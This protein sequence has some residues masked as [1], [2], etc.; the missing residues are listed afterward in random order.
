MSLNK[1]PTLAS[2]SL[3]AAMQSACRKAP[4]PPA[5]TPKDLHFCDPNYNANL[6]RVTVQGQTVI[7]QPVADLNVY[8]HQ[9]N[10]P[11]AAQLFDV[12]SALSPTYQ[13]CLGTP[14]V[15]PASYPAYRYRRDQN[16]LLNNLC[17]THPNTTSLRPLHVTLNSNQT[18]SLLA[19]GHFRQT[20]YCVEPQSSRDLQMRI[21][22]SQDEARRLIGQLIGVFTPSITF[23][24]RIPLTRPSPFY[25][26]SKLQEIVGALTVFA[27]L[28]PD[29]TDLVRRVVRLEEETGRLNHAV[30]AQDKRLR[31]LQQSQNYLQTFS[32]L[33]GLF[34]TFLMFPH[35]VA[36]MYLLAKEQGA[37]VPDHHI[38]SILNRFFKLM[39]IDFNR[40]RTI[41]SHP[42]SSLKGD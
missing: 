18:L 35:R 25:E 29:E 1:I 31:D 39:G 6:E 33:A 40:P 34:L 41:S 9:T 42:Q 32:L 19:M 22:P 37:L 7:F 15:N 16:E 36:Q 8:G 23:G 4:E 26:T 30:E 2:L 38:V 24:A 20:E 11:T 5:L 27:A 17:T 28:P 3:V 14:G 12:Q 10:N 13:L 21:N